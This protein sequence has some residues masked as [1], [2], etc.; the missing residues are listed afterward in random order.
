MAE[1]SAPSMVRDA[2]M[3]RDEVY[4]KTSGGG[5]DRLEQAVLRHL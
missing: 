2:A 3:A 4:G 5:R 1:V